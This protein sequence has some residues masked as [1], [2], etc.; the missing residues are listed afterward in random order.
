MFSEVNLPQNIKLSIDSEKKVVRLDKFS[1]IV[2]FKSKLDKTI[3]FYS[4]NTKFIYFYLS[5]FSILKTLYNLKY[6]RLNI[7][8]NLNEKNLK[9]L[10]EYKDFLKYF[11]LTAI[12]DSVIKPDEIVMIVKFLHSMGVKSEITYDLFKTISKE[13]L[14][15]I[16]NE[17][18]LNKE[19]VKSV[20]PLFS[21]T[22]YIYRKKSKKPIDKTL[23]DL[24]KD[25]IDRFSYIT[26]DGYVTI[27]KRWD[28]RSRYLF[29][30]DEA[31]QTQNSSE[32]YKELDAY[33]QNLFFK[34]LECAM[35]ESYEI[36]GAYLKF[37]DSKYD[38]EPFKTMLDKIE[39]NFDV[40]KEEKVA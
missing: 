6:K 37:E 1:N 25:K 40:F 5:D 7:V 30:L 22:N 35:C 19:L 16:T 28:K 26:R 15:N 14:E 17:I 18:I 36:C 21:F 11:R 2:S 34:N 3:E 27:S 32:L 4:K 23:W 31:N 24:F 29:N 38:C 8:F 10:K 13:D 20:E 39:K 33:E 9:L 12:L